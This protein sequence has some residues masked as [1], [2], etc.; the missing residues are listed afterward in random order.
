MTPSSVTSGSVPTCAEG[1]QFDHRRFADRRRQSEQL[2][3]HLGIA[4]QNGLTETQLKEA[5][6]H[7]AFTGLA[8]GDMRSSTTNTEAPQA[9]GSSDATD[10]AIEEAALAFSDPAVY[11]DHLLPRLPKSPYVLGPG[12]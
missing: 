9:P 12:R 7:L 5:I 10:Q 11:A 2:R 4:K 3:D 8:Q 6:I 1:S